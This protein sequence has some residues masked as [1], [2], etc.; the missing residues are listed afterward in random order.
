MFAKIDYVMVNVSDMARSVAFYRDQLGIA[1]R[2]ESPGWSEFE[3][4][5]TQLALHGGKPGGSPAAEHA[6][7]ASLGFNVDDLDRV[8]ADLEARGVRFVM[9]PKTQESEGIRLAVC[10]DP[11]GLPI[12]FAQRLS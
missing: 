9:P 4:G 10:V 5:A 2:F 3:T 11:D 8:V 1:L 6:G 7:T 12:S